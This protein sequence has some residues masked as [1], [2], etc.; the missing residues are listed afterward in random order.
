MARDS[1]MES[2]TLRD[3]ARGAFWGAAVGDALGWPQEMPGRRVRQA[4]HEAAA[5]GSFETWQR[6]SGGRFMPHQETIHAGEYSDDTQLLLC[7]ARAILRGRN[8]LKQ[9]AHVELPTWSAYERG[10]GGATKRAVEILANGSLPWS[11]EIDID[12]RRQ[13]FSAG[14][15]G[16]AMRIL[17]HAL[18]GARDESFL[19]TARAI[20]LN[21]ICT[22]GHPRALLGAL[23]YGY[24]AWQAFRHSGTLPYGYLLESALDDS[25][26]WAALPEAVDGFADWKDSANES[27]GGRLEGLWSQTTPELQRLLV[28]ALSGIKAGALSMDNRILSELGCFDRKVSGAGTISAVASIYLAS[29]YAPDPQHGLV[30]AAFSKGAD[31]DTL[32]SMVGALLGTVSGLDW[33]QTYRN[34]LQDESYLEKLAEQICGMDDDSRWDEDLRSTAPRPKAAID[35]FTH[36]LTVS[37]QGAS[38]TLPDGREARVQGHGQVSTNSATFRGD[39]WTLK[40]GDGQ[41]LHVKKLS[42]STKDGGEQI[43][44]GP[45]PKRSSPRRKGRFTTKVQAIKL[46]VRSLE[47]ARSFYGDIVGLKVERESKN[48]VNFGG[49]IS[50]VPLNYMSEIGSPVN[51]IEATRSI[52]CLETSNIDLCHVRV[53]EC[54]DARATAITAMAGRRF[55]RCF[56]PDQNVLEIFER[57]LKTAPPVNAPSS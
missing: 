11:R 13:Y 45:E 12:R 40:T 15:N 53:A 24:A 19:L 10:G 54:I 4:V 20:F 25:S 37:P 16:V 21:G 50:L 30:E 17:P 47:T 9:L 57:R 46:A 18:K 48:V 5:A 33:L 35:S 14:G 49:I 39:I 34:R 32:A 28:T 6:R 23:A 2:L 38:V 29:K 1:V 22:H 8:W 36:K 41:T 55:F 43:D 51:L 3:K 52:L 44:H 31:T 26:M 56:D 27:L 42:R 7:T